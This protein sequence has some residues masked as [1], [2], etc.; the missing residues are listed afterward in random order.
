MCLSPV[1]QA[2]DIGVL[3]D[4][5]LDQ[6]GRLIRRQQADLPPQQRCRE[7]NR[8]PIAVGAEIENVLPLRKPRGELPHVAQEFLYTDDPPLAMGE[9]GTGTEAAHQGQRDH[10]EALPGLSGKLDLKLIERLARQ[11]AGLVARQGVDE[12][13]RPGQKCGVDAL[14]QR[15][16]Q[17]V[18]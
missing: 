2:I 5:P 1:A 7:A 3:G 12:M 13:E 16:D 11:L 6:V 10:G 18:A 4:Q 9:H 14:T 8:E 15:V 17:T